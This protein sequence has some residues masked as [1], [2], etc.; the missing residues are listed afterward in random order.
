M[1]VRERIR[2][3]ISAMFGERERELGE[4]KDAC[5]GCVWGEVE[6]AKEEKENVLSSRCF[7]TFFQKLEGALGAMPLIGSR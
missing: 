5:T 6:G 2:V 7:T 4:K 1:S 3:L